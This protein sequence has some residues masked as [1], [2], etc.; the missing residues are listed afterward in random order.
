MTNVRIDLHLFGDLVPVLIAEW[1]FVKSELLDH[2]G[3]NLL[4]I[5]H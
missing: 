3:I 2:V 4:K 5:I 1:L